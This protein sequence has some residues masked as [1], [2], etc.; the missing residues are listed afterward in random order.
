MESEGEAVTRA[1]DPCREARRQ[2][3]KRIAQM[4]EAKASDI[5][6]LRHRHCS[7][8]ELQELAREIRELGD[9]EPKP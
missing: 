4:L 2:E 5:E 6:W 1:I 3:R 7:T 9:E 8:P